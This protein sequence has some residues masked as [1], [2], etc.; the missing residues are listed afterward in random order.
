MKY[1]LIMNEYNKQLICSLGKAVLNSIPY[2]FIF[3]EVSEI[4]SKIKQERLNKFTNQLLNYITNNVSIDFDNTT[5]NDFGDLFEEVVK[6]VINKENEDKIIFFRNILINNLLGNNSYDGDESFYIDILNKLNI[7]DLKILKNFDS[8]YQIINDELQK[9]RKLQTDLN[10]LKNNQF[11]SFD[12]IDGGGALTT[13][14]N[15]DKI[16]ICIEKLKILVKGFKFNYH[17]LTNVEGLDEDILFSSF[18][19][20]LSLGLLT[21]IQNLSSEIENFEVDVLS[22]TGESFLKFIREPK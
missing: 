12:H 13:E 18:N 17:L 6:N 22:K 4:R 20:L 3:T 16:K 15:S 10:K 8:Y 5:N 19:K 11:N 2:G 1:F 14:T 21:K 7:N 9:I